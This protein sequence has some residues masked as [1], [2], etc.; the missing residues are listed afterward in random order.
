MGR[1]SSV[2]TRSGVATAGKGRIRRDVH[3]TAPAWWETVPGA[4]PVLLIAPHGGLSQADLL[5]KEAAGRRANDLHTADL[6]REMARRLGAT[7]LINTAVDRNELDLN[8]LDDVSARAPW[9]L[10]E[11]ETHLGRLLRSHRHAVVLFVHGWHVGQARCDIGVG[12]SLDTAADARLHPDRLTVD[13][14]FVAGELERFRCG[15]ADDGMIATYGERWP[16]A[17]R[18]NAM[19]LFRRRPNDDPASAVLES[20]VREG[21]I[22]AV[23]LELGAPLRWPGDLR[24]RFVD[25][26]AAV[27]G[28]GDAPAPAARR[29]PPAPRPRG[30][31]PS[32]LS[33]QVFDPASGPHGIGV[34][35]G[36]MRL[37]PRDVGA[38]FQLLPGGQRM[39]IFTG[40]GTR[41]PVLGVP[42]LDFEE[43][44][45]GFRVSF[46]GWLLHSEDLG[47][48]FRSERR[49]ADADL[50]EARALLEVRDSGSG[51]GRVEG[52]IA[53]GR[54]RWLVDATGFVDVR[55]SGVPR[56]RAG[57]RILS[58]TPEGEGLRVDGPDA[59]GRWIVARHGPTGWV[60]TVCEGRVAADRPESWSLELAEGGRLDVQ[61]RSRGALLRPVGPKRYVHT[62][63]G[64]V[65]VTFAAERRAGFFEERRPI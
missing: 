64:L 8:R 17:H 25:R 40:H 49:Q 38:R 18:N 65:D 42:D 9:L 5:T 51:L 37:G 36:A 41:G 23:Q 52:E 3:S 27:W 58:A 21:R 14:D 34:V 56:G 48:Y 31:P 32:A 57:I 12:A 53:F 55:S 44:H 24:R 2:Q 13:P 11:L 1:T 60:E 28:E 20:L 15:L 47:D 29:R 7:A 39:G 61:W 50:V 43:T 16:A 62:T 4:A 26:V 35:A 45:D 54:E 30:E 33:V 22:Q 59:E 6:T 19:R 46:D 10:R 63:F